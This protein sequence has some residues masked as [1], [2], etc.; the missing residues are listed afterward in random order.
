MISLHI[1]A[2]TAHEMTEK[3]LAFVSLLQQGSTAVVADAPKPTRS[4]AS[5]KAAEAQVETK[6]EPEAAPQPKKSVFDEDDAAPAAPAFTKEQLQEQAMKYGAKHGDEKL[7][8]LVA[9]YS[10]TGKFSGIPVSDY[11]AMHAEMTA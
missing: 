1:E 7:E 11:A 6:A 4:R 3:L 10:S 2:E 8:A 5:A 9:K